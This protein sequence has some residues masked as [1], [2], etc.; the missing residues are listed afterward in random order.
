MSA[1]KKENLIISTEIERDMLGYPPKVGQEILA[2]L[3]RL[4]DNP[5]TVAAPK[6]V[7]FNKDHFYHRLPSG[8][9]VFWELLHTI[10]ER[11]SITSQEGEIVRITGVGFVFPKEYREFSL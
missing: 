10:P 11:P 4:A 9:Y 1:K 7:E 5:N 8:C 6:P 3:K 2:F